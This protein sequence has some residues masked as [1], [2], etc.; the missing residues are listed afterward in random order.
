MAIIP[1]VLALVVSGAAGWTRAAPMPTQRSEVAAAPFRGGI[2]VVGGFLP[3]CSTA[4]TAELYLPARNRW[5]RLPDLPVALNHA[6]A[7]SYRGRLYVIGGYGAPPNLFPR[8]AF[9]YDGVRWTR[10][11]RMPEARAAA[12][13]AI[14][15]G[16]VYVVGGVTPR[17]LADRA[18]VFDLATG[19]WSTAPGPTPREHL[20][21]TAVDGRLYALGGRV[22]GPD[23]NLDTFEVYSPESQRWDALQAV[24]EPRSGG[25]LA[26]AGGRLVAVGGERLTD[27]IRSV[28]A[29]DLAA[30]SWQR[31]ADFPTPRHGLAVVGVGDRVY[32]IGG[33]PIPDCGYSGLN[34][35]LRVGP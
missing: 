33:S 3:G 28:Y 23:S 27:T 34:Q 17:G 11:R 21:A 19:T 15:D 30:G 26:A 24:P 6:T 10:L 31:L 2:A 35:Y 29:F 7:A 18:L 5:R 9:V 16:K 32:A 8:S 25:G 13:S 1:A 12:A 22:G 4:R 14:V 20:A